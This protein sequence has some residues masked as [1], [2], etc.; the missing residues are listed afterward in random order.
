MVNIGFL[1]DPQGKFGRVVTPSP[2]AN[3]P[4]TLML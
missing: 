4:I 1:E 2:D 3:P